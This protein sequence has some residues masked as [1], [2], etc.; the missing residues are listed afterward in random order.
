[1]PKKIT[2]EEGMAELER[3]ARELETGA[4]PLN[5]SFEAFEK[6][7]KL[8]TSLEKILDDGDKKISMLLKDTEKEIDPEEL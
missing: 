5:E 4:M 8:K 2:F 6:A 1:M 7:M 3:I